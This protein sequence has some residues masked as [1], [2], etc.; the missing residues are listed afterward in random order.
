MAENLLQKRGRRNRKDSHSIYRRAKNYARFQPLY[1]RS[2]ATVGD[3]IK[4]PLCTDSP[5]TCERSCQQ[6]SPKSRPKVAS[7]FRRTLNV[8]KKVADLFLSGGK[9]LSAR[10]FSSDP[11]REHAQIEQEEAAIILI[12]ERYFIVYL[13]SMSLA[14]VCFGELD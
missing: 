14:V 10:V 13:H 9:K 11:S 8:I 2:K 12:R 7:D 4:F 3:K 5:L 1:G 6:K